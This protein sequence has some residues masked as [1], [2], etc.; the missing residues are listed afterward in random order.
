MKTKPKRKKVGYKLVKNHEYEKAFFE[1]SFTTIC[2]DPKMFRP[3][4]PVRGNKFD[5]KGN[6]ISIPPFVKIKK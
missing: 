4:C 2:G 6:L 3:P 5:K 1:I